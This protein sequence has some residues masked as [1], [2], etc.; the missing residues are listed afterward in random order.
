MIGFLVMMLMP[1][2]SYAN[3]SKITKGTILSLEKGELLEFLQKEG[4][5]L[6]R[7]YENHKDVAENFVT[8]FIPLILSGRVDT[9]VR[10]F[11]LQDSNE[12]LKNLETI[13]VKQGLL[14]RTRIKTFAV[15]NYKLKDS[16]PIG[17][18][19]D[20]YSHYNCYAYSIGRTKWRQPNGYEGSGYDCTKSVSKIADEVLKDLNKFGYWGYK[21]TTKPA[22]RPDNYF[23]VICVRKN[24]KD[25]DYHFMKMHG[26]SLNSWSHKP[27]TSQP[28]KWKYSSPGAKV[29]TNELIDYTGTHAPVINYDSEIYY[30]LYKGKNDPGIQPNG[31]LDYK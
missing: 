31:Y 21:T 8:D 30:I 11:N 24:S 28:L 15:N 12:M 17:S 22:S 26:S 19:S 3:D 1:Q 18:W 23:R 2:I 27:G 20:S 6:P 13:L 14:N 16:T 4:L 9:S 25:Y 29:W 10:A 5:V 7:Y